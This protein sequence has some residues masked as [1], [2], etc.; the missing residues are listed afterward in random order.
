MIGAYSDSYAGGRAVCAGVKVKSGHSLRVQ[1]IIVASV[2]IAP[3]SRKWAPSRRERAVFICHV[4]TV[5]RA[6]YGTVCH[7][8]LFKFTQTTSGSGRDVAIGALLITWHAL[9]GARPPGRRH[10]L[11]IIQNSF[12]FHSKGRGVD[13]KPGAAGRRRAPVATIII[14]VIRSPVELSGYPRSVDSNSTVGFD[15]DGAIEPT[16]YYSKRCRPQLQ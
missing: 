5:A 1:I 10:V 6:D 2:V 3:T 7:E 4:T 16:T 8:N 14:I 11:S 13:P 12:L 15:V 9:G